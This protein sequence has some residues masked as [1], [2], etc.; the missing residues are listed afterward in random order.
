MIQFEI[1]KHIKQFLKML[2]IEQNYYYSNDELKEELFKIRNLISAKKEDKLVSTSDFIAK[3]D[4]SCIVMIKKKQTL[5]DINGYLGIYYT[6]GKD[7]YVFSNM[8]PNQHYNEFQQSLAITKNYK[9]GILLE[10]IEKET[11]TVHFFNIFP[12]LKLDQKQ[13]FLD[14]K[15]KNIDSRFYKLKHGHYKTTLRKSQYSKAIFDHELN[16]ISIQLHKQYARMLE[17]YFTK[18]ELNFYS[19][20]FSY[21]ALPDKSIIESFEK[22]IRSAQDFEYLNNDK[23]KIKFTSIY[24][25]LFDL[26]SMHSEFENLTNFDETICDIL[27]KSE[28]RN[29][30]FN[31]DSLFSLNFENLYEDIKKE[32]FLHNQK[33]AAKNTL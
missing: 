11:E 25:I 1:E 15:T 30:N 3:V 23:T 9:N 14:V 29:L 12:I 19:Q 33:P 5:Q 21:D 16:L 13:S 10:K 20:A 22:K 6:F 28:N 26:K 7:F 8:M 32:Y 17:N 2:A 31:T 27:K 24:D 4:S 18:S